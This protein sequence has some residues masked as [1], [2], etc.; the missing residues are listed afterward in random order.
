MSEET[1]GVENVPAAEEPMYTKEDFV[2]EEV[3]EIEE[4]EEEVEEVQEEPQ[5][6]PQEET[7]EPQESNERAF[8]ERLKHAT[9]KIREEVRQE[10]MEELQ[11]TQQAQP[12]TQ[13]NYQNTNVPVLPNEEAERL[14]DQ[15]GTTPEVIRGMYAQQAMLNRQ[16]EMLQRI[17]M[18]SYERDEKAQARAYAEEVQ[19]NNPLAPKWDEK[20]LME[21]K[22][23]YEKQYGARLTWRDTYRQLVAEE[24]LSGKKYQESIRAAQQDTLKKI[25]SKDKDTVQIKG[26]TAIKPSIADLSDEEFERFLVEAEEGKYI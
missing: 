2:N 9:K 23:D 5:E 21:F 7:Q 15:Y 3:E 6:E 16:A 25:T 19:G 26:K 13:P 20:R 22:K 4:T 24:A 1:T 14:A 17:T 8:A 18:D 12:T 10:I 11:Q